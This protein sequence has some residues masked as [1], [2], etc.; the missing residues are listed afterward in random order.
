MQSTIGLTPISMVIPLKPCLA[1]TLPL[2]SLTRPSLQLAIE[3]KESI[4][5]RVGLT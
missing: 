2:P 4:L 1:A 5:H 3:A